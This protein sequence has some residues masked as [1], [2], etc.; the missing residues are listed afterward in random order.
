L[1]LSTV[2]VTAGN[3][4]L[5]TQNMT[6]NSPFNTT[7]T[8][9]VQT[10]STEAST[11]KVSNLNLTVDRTVLEGAVR[12]SIGGSCVEWSTLVSRLRRQ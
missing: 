12:F 2:E 4:K 6:L 3:L 7:L 1:N 11:I 10:S 5:N 8:I 9:P